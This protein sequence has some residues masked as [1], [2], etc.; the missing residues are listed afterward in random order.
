MIIEKIFIF[1]FDL[2]VDSF[3]LGEKVC[4]DGFE[5]MYIVGVWCGGV[6]IGIVVQ[7]YFEFKGY[8]VDYIVICILFYMGIDEQLWEVCVYGE[9]YFVDILNVDDWVL[10]VDDVFDSGCLIEVLLQVLGCKCWCNFLVDICIVMVYFKLICN[11]IDFLLDYF[12]YECDEWLVFLY[13][14]CGLGED[15]FVLFG[16]LVDLRGGD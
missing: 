1:V 13:E 11:Q 14:F 9:G 7:E 10:I 15:E 4:V 12:I 5:L 8:K 3:C 2:Q 6:F 16:L